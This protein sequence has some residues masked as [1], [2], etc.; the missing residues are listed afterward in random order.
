MPNQ[1]LIENDAVVLGILFL[2]LFGIFKLAESSNRF[3]VSFFKIFPPI[4]LCYFIPGVLNSVGFFSGQNSGIYPFVSKYLLPVCL[5]LF[6]LS[7]DIDMLKKLGLKSVLVFLAGTLGVILGGPLAAKV[8][9][10]IMPEVFTGKEGGELWRGLGTIAGSWIGGGANQTAIKEIVKPSAY[11]FSQCVAVDVLVA[12]TWLAVLLIGVGYTKRIDTW[13]GADQSL[14]ADMKAKLHDYKTKNERIPEFMDYLT[15]LSV[16]FVCMGIAY[17]F[18]DLIVPYISANH[19]SW[20]KFSLTSVFFWVVFITTAL[21]I[22]LSQ[23]KVRELENVGA[24][25]IAT[26]ILYILVASIGMQMDLLAISQNLGLFLVGIIWI[27]IHV[28]FVLTAA[29]ILKVPYFVMAVGSQANIGGAASASV[30]A[31]AFHP[32]LVSVG[33]IFSVLG[34]SVGTYGGYLTALLIRWVLA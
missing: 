3:L 4:L 31:G 23:T 21:G 24:S 9:S 20:S 16:G 14:V 2:I 17:F 25:K 28:I 30:V 19:P 34:Y 18:A 5:L 33:V 10:V 11:V 26:L 6:T 27:F 29:K 13:L 22:F 1:V 8:V 12:E 32:T 15:I 7:L